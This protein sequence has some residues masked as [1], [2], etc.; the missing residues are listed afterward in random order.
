LNPD[1][2]DAW[3]A[4]VNSAVTHTIGL[5]QFTFARARG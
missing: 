1:Y 5:A 2:T 4:R 3:A